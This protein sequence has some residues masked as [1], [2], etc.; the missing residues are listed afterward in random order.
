MPVA[1]SVVLGCDVVIHHPGLVNLYGCR[2]GDATRVWAFVEIQQGVTVG[3]RCKTSS[4]F[5][6]HDGADCPLVPCHRGR[7]MG[8]P[9]R[10]SRRHA[11]RRTDAD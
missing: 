8:R 11:I 2:I 1:D 3:A 4:F 6:V 5:R 7:G 10:N 9:G